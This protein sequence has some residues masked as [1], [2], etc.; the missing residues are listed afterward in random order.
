MKDERIPLVEHL[1]ELRRR[2]FWVIITWIVLSCVSWGLR[3]EIFGFLA[4][5]AIDALAQGHSQLQ[6][7]TPGEIFFTYF[8]CSLLAGFIFATPMVFWHLWCFVAPGLYS[9]EK[10]VI[11]SF[12]LASTVLFVGGG[13]FAYYFVFPEV[14]KFF[15]SFDSEFV[16][17]VWTMAQ[18]FGFTSQMFLAFGAAFELPVIVIALSMAGVVSPQQLW[19]GTPYAAVIA[20]IIGAVLTPNDGITQFLLAVPL[21]VLYLAAVGLSFLMR[22]G[23]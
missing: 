13:V 15:V 11:V 8:K 20:F 1:A 19:K 5:P 14:F 22:R 12:V 18:I 9:S 2:L 23:R 6:A 4:Q 3:E 21:L 10:K 7:I 17:S 16:K